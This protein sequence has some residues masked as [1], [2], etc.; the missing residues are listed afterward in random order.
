MELSVEFLLDTATEK[1]ILITVMSDVNGVPC[2][3]ST[4]VQNIVVEKTAKN[5][6][7][8]LVTVVVRGGSLPRLAIQA[9]AYDLVTGVLPIGSDGRIPLAYGAATR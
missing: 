8:V 7:N 1:T 6:A 9:I 4:Q 5:K 2:K 3:K